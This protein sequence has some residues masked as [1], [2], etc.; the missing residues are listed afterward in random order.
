VSKA[1]TDTLGALHSALA[2]KMAAMLRGEDV[3]ASVLKEIREFLK[4]NGIN[5]DGENS[6]PLQNLTDTLPF[7]GT[8]G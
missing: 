2:E 7:T 5:A 3:P 6:V 1:T 8:D 4:D